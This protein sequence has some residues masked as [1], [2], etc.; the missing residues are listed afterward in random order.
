M[1][2]ACGARTLEEHRVKAELFRENAEE[3]RTR[4]IS[5]SNEVTRELMHRLATEYDELAVIYERLGAR[6]SLTR[7]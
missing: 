1:A 7:K 5:I 3:I 4:A 2:A 6:K